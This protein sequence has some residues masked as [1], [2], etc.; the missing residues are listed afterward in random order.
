[1]RVGLG[2]WRFVL[3]VGLLGLLVGC[4]D[5][6]WPETR[7][8]DFTVH[9]EADG[10]ELPVF[11]VIELSETTNFYTYAY[12]GIN[13]EV[14][15]DTRTEI[16]DALFE[17]FRSN[18]FDT[19]MTFEDGRFERGGDVLQVSWGEEMLEVN[20]SGPNFVGAEAI[21]KWSNSSTG[22]RQVM[23]GRTLGPFPSTFQLQFDET[24]LTQIIDIQ[25]ELGSVYRGVREGEEAEFMTLLIAEGSGEQEML[26]RYVD[27]TVRYTFDADEEKGVRFFFSEAGL[28]LE[29]IEE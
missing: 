22:V 7:P 4:N 18:Q 24:A 19:I 23:Y 6:V 16:L 1:M 11:Q 27:Q 28:E 14:S 20:N 21:E 15:F 25:F 5:D 29:R 9:Y 8:G 17:L 10:G 2:V 13:V 3:G 26:V 12:A